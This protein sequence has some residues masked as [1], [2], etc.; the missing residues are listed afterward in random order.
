M[1][2]NERSIDEKIEDTLRTII[3]VLKSYKIVTTTVKD[4][5]GKTTRS[6]RI[7]ER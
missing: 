4:Q 2:K 7:E 1:E 3:R 6:Y 5:S